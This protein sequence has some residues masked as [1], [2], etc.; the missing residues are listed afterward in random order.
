MAIEQSSIAHNFENNE[1]CQFRNAPTPPVKSEESLDLANLDFIFPNNNNI[2][3]LDSN[4]MLSTNFEM[5]IPTSFS[6]DPMFQDPFVPAYS[7]APSMNSFSV[8]TSTVSSTHYEDSPAP[9]KITTTKASRKD[10]CM[11]KNAIAARENRQKKKSE[12]TDLRQKVGVLQGESVTYKKKYFE[13]KEQFKLVQNQNQYYE[14]ILGNLPSIMNIIEHMQT[15]PKESEN[16]KKLK[17]KINLNNNTLGVCFHV[18]T[19][20]EMSLKFCE[21]CS[22]A[23]FSNITKKKTSET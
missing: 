4:L 11:T 8:P 13:M 7:P 5:E 1:Y 23:N 6:P 3:F 22:N 19:S 16:D 2:D 12:L 14:S 10:R 15:M 9:G 17:N 18:K 21:H 20:K